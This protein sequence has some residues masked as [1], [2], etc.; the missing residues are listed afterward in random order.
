M[1]DDI[2][3]V[4][5]EPYILTKVKFSFDREKFTLATGQARVSCFPTPS[6]KLMN[7][8]LSE[9]KVSHMKNR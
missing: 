4:D 6:E 8:N 5:F 1:Y 9:A 7:L 3:K 2:L